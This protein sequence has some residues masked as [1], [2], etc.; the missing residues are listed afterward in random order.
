MRAPS[1]EEG[2]NNAYPDLIS[3]A[4]EIAM[5]KNINVTASQA[6]AF[7]QGVFWGLPLALHGVGPFAL[8]L[9]L[10]FRHFDAC[11]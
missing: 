10:R 5:Q 7:D 4:A 1:H 2:T 9:G 3:A 6:E 8:G 11:D